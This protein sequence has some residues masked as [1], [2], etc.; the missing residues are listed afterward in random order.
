MVRVLRHESLEVRL[1]AAA[2]Q[3]RVAN[4]A[5]G[6]ARRGVGTYGARGI[7]GRRN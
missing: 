7:G 5:D 3:R 4:D 1:A 6:S 2:L